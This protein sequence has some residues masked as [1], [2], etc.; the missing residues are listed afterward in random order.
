MTLLR[1]LAKGLLS[2]R[3]RVRVVGLEAI[4]QRG[5]RG[6]LFLPNHPALIDP[7]LVFLNLHARF[8]PRAVADRDQIEASAL[9]RWAAR[10]A[11]IRS[12]PDIKKYG[13]AV[14]DDVRC[15]LDES[16]AGLRA[17]ENLL[18]YPSGHLYQSRYEHLYGNSAV[19]S[20]LRQ[21]PDARVVLVRTRG[22]WGSSFSQ[23]AG[24]LPEFG[25]NLWRRGWGLLRSFL[26][27]A[28][29]RPVT[30]ELF[31]PDDFPRHA[32]RN[33]QNR[34]LESFYNQDAPPN[35]YVPYSIWE[36]GGPRDLPDPPPTRLAGDVSQV[37]EAVRRRV[38]D[39]LRQLSGQPDPAP[40]Q[41][42]GPDL[43]L[44]SLA[45]AEL[46]VWLEQEFSF[47]ERDI[48]AIQT[49]GDVLLAARGQAVVTRL[50]PIRP[51]PPKWFRSARP[52]RVR[53]RATD[54]LLRAFLAQAA[55]SPSRPIIADQISGPRTYRDL[56][57]AVLALR[58]FVSELPGERI[59]IL[60]PASVS[61][62]VA[63]LAVLFSGRTPVFLNW[64]TGPRNLRHALDA[65]K[66]DRILTAQALVTRLQSQG[67]DL[68]SLGDK[69]V[70]LERIAARITRFARLR[71]W[72]GARLSWATLRRAS[73]PPVIAIL[74]TSGSE[75]VPKCVPLTAR[76]VLTNIADVT[77][78]VE[79]RGDDCM[80]GFLPPFHSFGLTVTLLAPLV[81][82]FPVVYHANPTEAGAIVRLIETYK[83]TLLCGTP[84]FLSGLLRVARPGQLDSLRLAVTGAEKCPQHTHE[85]LARQCPRAIILEGYGITECSPIV[86]ATRPPNPQLGTIGRVMATLEYAV[87]DAE[88][89]C[90]IEDGRPGLLLVRGPSVFDGYLG[91]APSPFVEFEG[92]RWYRTGDLVSE[93]ADGTLTFRGRLKRFVKIGGEMIS[94]PAIEAA[95]ERRFAGQSDEGPILAVESTGDEQRPEL[96][97]FT[98]QNIER[99]AAN[100]AL[101]DAGLSPLHNLA[102]VRLLEALPL[103]G[104]G[105]TD[106][107][108]L[109]ERL[110]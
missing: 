26:F 66:I 109:R 91:D 101:R 9:T 40:Q 70:P 94:L 93:A 62:V 49:V 97:L 43:G 50:T 13:P 55:R 44:D 78:A 1:L 35:R 21:A 15:V 20:L 16:C 31:E 74:L 68:S 75:T 48:D 24:T 8:A 60:L 79:L 108:A 72:L 100:Q 22:L 84:T 73:E 54:S 51:P 102:S 83:A 19:E 33:E 36:R 57:T 89:G 63:C 76:N 58:P 45:R 18:I 2:L 39:H 4:A 92:E 41:R 6:I 52:E 64:T 38:L 61:A 53:L 110:G 47:T 42:L 5:T 99:N 85:Q 59:G 56:V 71:A 77:D 27:F 105:K 23:A 103:L 30:I 80:I 69:L 12:L 82:G 90:R 34:Y 67:I 96:V 86:S 106:Y 104:T 11:G 37:P 65:L 10:R 25:P 17:G 88:S 28:P 46:L 81:L 14:R 3:Y 29:R 7:V 107:R 32:D 95:L 98:T 87:I